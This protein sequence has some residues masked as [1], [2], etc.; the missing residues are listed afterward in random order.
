[1]TNETKKRIEAYQ[2]ALPEMRERVLAV[3]LL[4]AISVATLTTASFAWLTISRAPEVTSVSTSIA[5]NGNLEIA[6]ANSDED[7]KVQTPAESKVGDSSAT[8]GQDIIEANKTWGNLVN[9]SDSRYGLEDLILRPAQLNYSSLLDSPLYGAVYQQD[10][11]V[12]KLNSS[13]A[14]ATWNEKYQKFWVTKDVGEGLGVRAISSVTIENI[15]QESENKQ[16]KRNIAE[17]A[18]LSAGALYTTIT[19]NSAYMNTLATVMGTYMTANLNKDHATLSNPDVKQEDVINLRDLFED[20]IEVYDAQ[21]FAMAE[22]ANYQLFLLKDGNVG[23]MSYSADTMKTKTEAD[24][25]RDGIQVN[26]LNTAKSDYE[27][28]LEGYK[29]LVDL[30]D[31]G[32]I[33]WADSGLTD[34]V[35]NLMNTGSCTLDGTPVSSIGASKALDYISGT[36]EAKITNGVLYNF[37]KLNGARC[38][39]KGLKVNATINRKGMTLPGTVTVNITTSAPFTSQNSTDLKYGDTL[40][41][42]GSGVKTA[43]DTY[44]LAIDMWV[45]TNASNSFLVLEGNVLTTSEEVPVVGKD[46]KGN[47]VQ[48]YTITRTGQTDTGDGEG[49]TVSFTIDLYKVITKDEENADVVTWYNA[50]THGIVDLEE[51]ET[52]TIKVEKVVTVVGYEGENRIWEDANAWEENSDLSLDSTTQGSGSCYVYYADSP[53]DQARSLKLLASMNIVF[54]DDKGTILATAS[55]DTERFYAD[56]GRVTVPVVLDGDSLELSGSEEGDTIYAITPLAKNEPKRITAIIYLD[57]TKLTN[58]DVLS[59]AEIQ[60]KLNLQ[61]GSSTTLSHA[62]DETLLSATR[63]V[64][65][66]VDV[67]KF[68]YDVSI[69]ENIPM[70]TTVTVNVEGDTPKEV[71]AFFIRAISATQGSREKEM[72][73]QPKD[74]SWTAEHVFTVPGEYILRSIEL[75]GQNYDLA[76]SPIVTIEGFTINSLECVGA[77]NRHVNIMTASGSGAVDLKLQFATN[78]EKAMPATVQGRFI[79]EEDGAAVNVNF[80]YDGKFW[81]GKATFISSGEYKLEYLLLNGEYTRIPESMI[82]TASVYLGMKVAVYTDSPMEFDY[83]ADLDDNKENLY[84]R[85]KIKDN[86]GNELENLPDVRLFYT[87][88]GSTVNGFD[89]PITWNAEEKSYTG[90]FQSKVGTYRFSHVTVGTNTITYAEIAPIFRIRSKDPTVYVERHMDAGNTFYRGK[91]DAT[92]EAIFKESSTATVMALI[93]KDS[94]DTSTKY[95]V[96][97]EMIGSATNDATKETK[98]TF[99]LPDNEKQDGV[100]TMEEVYAWYCYNENSEYLE[101]E[102]RKT[103]DDSIWNY[104]ERK[105]IRQDELKFSEDSTYIHE[106]VSNYWIKVINTITAKFTTDMSKNFSGN[107]FMN[108]YTVS[109]LSVDFTDYQGLAVVDHNNNPFISDVKVILTYNTGTSEKYGYYSSSALNNNGEPIKITI[110]LVDETKTGMQ[111]VQKQNKELLYAG[112]YTT[113]LQ[114]SVAGTLVSIDAK[115]IATRPVTNMPIYIVSTNK[116]TVTISDITLDGAG[117]YSVDTFE[118]GS[119]SDDVKTSGGCLGVGATNNYT[120]HASHL[121]A[122]KNTQYISRISDDN[123]TAWLYFKCSHQDIA[124]YSDSNFVNRKPHAYAYSNGEG[125]PAV[126]MTLSDMGQATNAKLTFTKTG[127][128]DVVMITQYTADRT[129]GTYW[130]D[131][132]TFG[133]DSFEWT[134]DGTCKRFIGVMDNGAGEN[135]SDSKTV[136]GTITA[137]TLVLSYG[138]DDYSFTID[139]I[140]INNPY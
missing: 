21:F 131:Q 136:A 26:G 121:F 52:P 104:S 80:A 5:A 23:T 78:Q 56:N 14:Y 64:R 47:S 132:S 34:I 15:D 128:G 58:Q 66:S 18:N 37:E 115:D 95:Y 32:T 129:G 29:T 108:P 36:H 46:A 109:G 76:E 10:G 125:V 114:Y 57:G 89:T 59:A 79:R 20:F 45:R 51:G 88:E 107:D 105:W 42:G 134:A 68:N 90:T 7:N 84:M 103:A 65:A 63:S 94:K 112:T 72:I 24:L 38:E 135:G 92:M 101:T 49:E 41:K 54:I 140:T 81:N 12:E 119:I 123:K 93:R 48:I 17:Q 3:A 102:L 122:S 96:I 30:A 118:T 97:G 83:E 124:T 100:W 137:D 11:R 25:K 138:G 50:T 40:N 16:K 117:A 43:E 62:K 127:G 53:E 110:D 82:Q 87:M 13:F 133:T 74:G 67:N 4:L 61:F 31:D 120:T 35:N 22:L 106:N 85:V 73:F 39:V 69:A 6:L 71:K 70:K 1:M 130:G 91:N 116:P 27:K 99:R 98:W 126:T 33:K 60:G 139:T 86:T 113:T 75:D 9:L 8:K 44:G 28:L 2:K 77:D 55:M 111:F 19:K